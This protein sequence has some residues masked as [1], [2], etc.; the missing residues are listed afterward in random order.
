MGAGEDAW[1]RTGSRGA[2]IAALL[3]MNPTTVRG[4][5]RRRLAVALP[6]DP[7]GAKVDA[8]E[9]VN[10]REVLVDWQPIKDPRMTEILREHGYARRRRRQAPSAGAASTGVKLKGLSR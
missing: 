9:P 3:G 1:R 6:A 4:H 2:L 8:F 7:A 10:P 5:A